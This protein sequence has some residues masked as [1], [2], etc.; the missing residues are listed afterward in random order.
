MHCTNPGVNLKLTSVSHPGRRRQERERWARRAPRTPRPAPAAG[1]TQGLL[2]TPLAAA[3]SPAPQVSAG[4]PLGG[5]RRSH[6]PPFGRHHHHAGNPPPG[7]SPDPPGPLRRGHRVPRA[8]PPASPAR[9]AGRLCPL[10]DGASTQSERGER[11]GAHPRTRLTQTQWVRGRGRPAGAHC[12]PTPSLPRPWVGSVASLV[13]A[14]PLPIS[15]GPGE[16]REP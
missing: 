8:S 4:Q 3:P 5:A 7:P 13:C 10:P 16:P 14:S 1:R 2:E 11:P 12:G 9:K 15:P 6:P